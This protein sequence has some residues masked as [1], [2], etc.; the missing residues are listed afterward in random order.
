MHSL[1]YKD[2]ID[3]KT[4]EWQSGLKKLEEQA[5]KAPSDTREEF[6]AKIAQLRSAI[7]AATAQ[8][9][10]L[11]AMETVANTMETKDKILKIF[12]SIDK[13]FTGYEE[14]TPYML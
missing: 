7:A 11:D 14:K 8:L 6:N 12:S 3:E 5:G 13:D 2:I 9:H 1:T 4:A 10:T